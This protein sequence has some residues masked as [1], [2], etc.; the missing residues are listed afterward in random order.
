MD[1]ARNN[2]LV[3]VSSKMTSPLPNVEDLSSNA[4]SFVTQDE[5]RKAFIEVGDPLRPFQHLKAHQLCCQDLIRII[6]SQREGISTLST[7][8]ENEKR[9]RLS[10]QYELKSK[11]EEHEK[12]LRRLVSMLFYHSFSALLFLTL[13]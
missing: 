13:H 3:D 4:S 12:T 11:T 9:S 5:A 2:S 10:Y 7:E 8:L 6:D 1:T